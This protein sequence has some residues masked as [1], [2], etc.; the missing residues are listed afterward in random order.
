M[1]PLAL[2]LDAGQLLIQDAGN[3]RDPIKLNGQQHVIMIA[4]SLLV[5]CTSGRKAKISISRLG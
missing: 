1:S 4:S 5:L 2:V 3:L